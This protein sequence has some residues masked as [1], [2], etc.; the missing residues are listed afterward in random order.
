MR[1]VRRQSYQCLILPEY[2]WTSSH[3]TYPASDVNIRYSSIVNPILVNIPSFCP[4][5]VSTWNVLETAL[6]ILSSMSE[7]R[8]A[9]LM[10]LSVTTFKSYHEIGICQT[11]DVSFFITGVISTSYIKTTSS[12]RRSFRRCHKWRFNGSIR[13]TKS[14]L[15]KTDLARRA[16]CK[17][18]N[19][20]GYFIFV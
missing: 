6:V 10:D 18:P 20:F 19:D 16:P 8:C 17:N 15:R 11:E 13:T 14:S 12:N 2:T 4:P 9:S 1:Y 3:W 7:S 5:I